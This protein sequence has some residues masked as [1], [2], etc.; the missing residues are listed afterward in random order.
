MGI[1]LKTRVR[2]RTFEGICQM[3][4]DG[5]GLGIVPETAARRCGRSTKIAA[6]RLADDWAT[7]RLSVCIRSGEELTAPAR[8][9][10]EHL[11]SFG[12]R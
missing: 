3:A 2:L 8:D 7:R 9:L 12:A 1:K 4:A 11:A 6:I 5:V 10:F